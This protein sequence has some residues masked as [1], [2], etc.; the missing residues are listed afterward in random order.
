MQSHAVKRSTSVKR[1][2][3]APRGASRKIALVG[4]DGFQILDIAGPLE[5]FTKAAQHLPQ[6]GPAPF[7]YELIVASPRGGAISSSSGLQIA[8]TRAIGELDDD[9][10]TIV[11]SGGPEAALRAVATT[12]DLVRWI[13]ERAPRTRRIASVCTGAFLL[14]GCGLL[15]GRRATT[16]WSATTQLAALFPKAE[17]VPDAIFIG[18]G[19][20]HTSAGV[21]AGID[22]SLAL[23]EQDCGP[24]VALGVARDLVLY[25]R[26]VGGQSQ[27][28]AALAAQ[29]RAADGL[30]DLLAW[31]GEH[32]AD[33]LGIPRLAGRAGM[34]ERSF[35]R[36]FAAKTG[37]TPA[38]YVE[39]VRLDRAKLLLETTKWPLARIAD[40]SGL[41]H[42]ATLA[43]AFRRKL[44]ITPEDYRARF[45]HGSEPGS[46]PG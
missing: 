29:A 16:H 4:F 40:R 45:R 17:V 22:L 14:G 18:D 3:P 12:T 43:R 34:S 26:R 27:F 39:L 41:G 8:A 42:A 10:D 13:A 7:R 24:V 9:L 1:S 31:I 5:V 46:E 21:T 19:H 30:R 28:S 35:G 33:D 20:I 44:G 11:I 6:S 25:L 2:T 37:M 23:V 15:D 36:A 32:P 38:R